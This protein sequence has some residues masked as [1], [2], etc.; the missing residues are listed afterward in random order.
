MDFSDGGRCLT[1]FDLVDHLFPQGARDL[2]KVS[3]LWLDKVHVP[4]LF[5]STVLHLI[6]C[7]INNSFDQRVFRQRTT[8]HAFLI[9]QSITVSL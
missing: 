8:S 1:A 5:S 6:L 3:L 7:K 9:S 4:E 2:T